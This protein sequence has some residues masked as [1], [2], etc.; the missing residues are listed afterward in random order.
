MKRFATA[1][2]CLVALLAICV[3]FVACD[4][5]SQ[6][7]TYTVTIHQGEGLEDIVW[8]ID[9]DIPTLTKDGFIVEGLYL[10]DNFE[11]EVSLLTLKR[12]GLTQNINV[13]VKWQKNPCSHNIVVDRAI[14]PTCT[15]SGLTEGSHCSICNE[16]FI[17]QQEI[18]ALGHDFISRITRMPTTEKQGAKLLK[19]KT[20]GWKKTE[21]LP[22]LEGARVVYLTYDMFGIIPDEYSTAGMWIWKNIDKT[23]ELENYFLEHGYETSGRST[24]SQAMKQNLTRIEYRE[25]NNDFSVQ[26]FDGNGNCTSAVYH[27]SNEGPDFAEIFADIE[28]NGDFRSTKTF[29]AWGWD[30]VNNQFVDDLKAKFENAGYILAEE[31]EDQAFANAN[32]QVIFGTDNGKPFYGIIVL[33]SE[34]GNLSAV[35]YNYSVPSDKEALFLEKDDFANA[36]N[37]I[38]DSDNPISLSYYIDDDARLDFVYALAKAG[39]CINSENVVDMEGSKSSTFTQFSEN[40]GYYFF[41]SYFDGSGK[42]WQIT[43]KKNITVYIEARTFSIK[44][45]ASEGG[46]IIGE[47]DQ[48][49]R[50]SQTTQTVKAVAYNGYKF[51]GWSDGVKTAER[52]DIAREDM[53][54]TALFEKRNDTIL[55]N[56]FYIGSGFSEETDLM[57]FKVDGYEIFVLD[58]NG[59]KTDVFYLISQSNDYT[60]EITVREKTYAL[61]QYSKTVYANENAALYKLFEADITTSFNADKVGI[62]GDRENNETVTVSADGK[63]TAFGVTQNVTKI[64]G[65]YVGCISL[66]EA[67]VPDVPDYYKKYYFSEGAID[68]SFGQDSSVICSN[69]EVKYKLYKEAQT[70]SQ[71]SGSRI[72]AP[73]GSVGKYKMAVTDSSIEIKEDGTVIITEQGTS[74]EWQ[75]YESEGTIS[76]IAQH[77]DAR[78]EVLIEFDGNDVIVYEVNQYYKAGMIYRRI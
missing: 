25:S 19:C 77:I 1:V 33:S 63:I 66:S 42:S 8:N 48:S 62:Y 39:Y 65:V 7:T 26:Y 70:L 15:E 75:L 49:V 55:P 28:S 16:I 56:G 38:A 60:I 18:A 27:K 12:T 14:L 67:G 34:E 45:V 10:D 46:Q 53:T 6:E 51:V 57:F 36:D 11:E 13:Y 22:T 31:Q 76:I 43:F 29:I 3:F 2:F 69:I 4:K 35:Q 68:I 21:L 30:C 54:V 73:S 58:D 23:A 78:I 44:Y 41:L 32:V 40:G 64:D 37:F 71:G 50:Q 72:S 74:N 5:N 52:S 59:N 20:C 17:A 9:S 61:L 24:S 47:A